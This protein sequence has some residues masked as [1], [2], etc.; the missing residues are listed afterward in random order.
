MRIL[1]PVTVLAPCLGNP[2]KRKS[3]ALNR[4]D[5]GRDKVHK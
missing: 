3:F 5:G 2:G 1:I 4:L